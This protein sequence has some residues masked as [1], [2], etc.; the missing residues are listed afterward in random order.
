MK[1][2]SLP[3]NIA[4]QFSDEIAALAER[5]QAGVVVIRR[6]QSGRDGGGAGSGVVWHASGLIATNHHVVGGGPVSVA[7]YD[8]TSYKTIGAS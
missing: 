4:S 3:A 5:S 1:K 8:G 6:S 7:F 2:M